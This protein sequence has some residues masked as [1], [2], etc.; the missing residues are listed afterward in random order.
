MDGFTFYRKK[1]GTERVPLGILP[2]PQGAW[3]IQQST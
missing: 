2:L 3:E 1:S